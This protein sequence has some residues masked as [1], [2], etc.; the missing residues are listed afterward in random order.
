MIVE[1]ALNIRHQVFKPNG[2]CPLFQKK[3]TTLVINVQK[4]KYFDYF[5][6]DSFVQK[7]KIL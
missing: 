4:V 5:A 6:M 7:K 2:K 3:L 1:N